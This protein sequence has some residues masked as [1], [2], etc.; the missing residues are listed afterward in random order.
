MG[1][2]L[3]ER[4]NKALWGAAS[5]GDIATIQAWLVAG[6]DVNADVFYE[7]YFD[8]R[9]FPTRLLNQA[10]SQAR[11][12]LV[13]VL[14]ANGADINYVDSGQMSRYHEEANP[15]QHAVSFYYRYSYQMAPSIEAA[16]VLI[17][18]G[19]N[20]TSQVEMVDINGET[21]TVYIGEVRLL[22]QA[23]RNPDLLRALLRAGIRVDGRDEKGKD[24]EAFI[25]ADIAQIKSMYQGSSFGEL[26]I[27]RLEESA[28]ILEG[29][30]LAGTYKR[31]FLAPHHSMLALRALVLRG[32]AEPF[33]HSYF[34]GPPLRPMQTVL[35][36]YETEGCNSNFVASS[37][38]MHLNQVRHIVSFLS[39]E[40]ELL[41]TRLAVAPSFLLPDPVF[42]LI[43]EFWLGASADEVPALLRAAA[44]RREEAYR[45][46]RLV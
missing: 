27:Q 25:Q 39:R 8:E 6:G 42:F 19:A 29:T 38:P 30:R 2:E 26:H 46:S 7:H 37:L 5:R 18:A 15:L 20:L 44:R 35:N 22:F 33:G 16:L 13:R 24:V 4:N 10:A 41:P 11:A 32:R 40:A 36:F 3:N 21:E 23:T 43:L 12:E 31:Y 9:R 34:T 45:R 28:R 17:N 1:V 14:I